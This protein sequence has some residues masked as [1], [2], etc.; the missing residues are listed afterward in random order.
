[1]SYD[2]QHE[3]AEDRI[4]D[5]AEGWV[6]PHVERKETINQ[7]MP[8]ITRF[9]QEAG[10]NYVGMNDDGQL[11]FIGTDSQWRNFRDLVFNDER[12]YA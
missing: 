2:K 12:A 6:P 8:H 1:M 4:R 5:M 10:M 7:N 3:E 9:A 11:E